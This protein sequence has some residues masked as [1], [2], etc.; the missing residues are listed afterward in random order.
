MG[1]VPC[2]SADPV[3]GPRLPHG[4]AAL[5]PRPG[6]AVDG[7]IRRARATPRAT[8][9]G[10]P[11][12]PRF[13]AAV[14]SLNPAIQALTPAGTYGPLA[15]QEMRW[16]GNNPLDLASNLRGL[17]LTLRTGN[18]EPGGPFGG[19]DGVEYVVHRASVALHERLGALGIPHVWDDYGPGVHLW[20]YWRR[21]LR[22]TLPWLMR[23]IRASARPPSPFSYRTIAPQLPGLRLAGAGQAAR[24]RVERAERR[25]PGG[26]SADGQRCR[27]C[28]ERAA[29]PPRHAGARDGPAGKRRRAAPAPGGRR[30]RARDAPATA[31]TGEC[32]AAVHAGCHHA[33]LPHA[34]AA[35]SRRL[36]PRHPSCPVVA[37]QPKV[38]KVGP[39]SRPR[40]RRVPA[41]GSAPG[42]LGPWSARAG[43]PPTRSPG[44]GR[45][46]PPRS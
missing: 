15:T 33:P 23:A 14:D 39:R 43:P 7:R 30:G 5:R 11:P 28:D 3:G 13:S 22:Q 42:P 44:R 29:L 34:R 4:H 16:R 19:G 24:A 35:G 9:T 1:D 37:E 40:G 2:H 31:W 21:D 38:R 17:R 20:P 10:S 41:A 8:R 12:P 6:R 27:Q 25:R 36:D 18:G 46:G 32:R 45:G 26:F